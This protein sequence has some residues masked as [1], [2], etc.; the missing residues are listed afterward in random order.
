M[1][2]RNTGRKAEIAKVLFERRLSKLMGEAE[3]CER[4]LEAAGKDEFLLH[5]TEL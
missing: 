2:E 4:E 1:A 3:D 5:L